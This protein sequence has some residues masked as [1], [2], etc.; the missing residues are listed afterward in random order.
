MGFVYPK[1]KFQS[2]PDLDDDI[3]DGGLSMVPPGR[4]LIMDVDDSN[5]GRILSS[6]VRCFCMCVNGVNN[7]ISI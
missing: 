3:V 1:I 2:Y 6:S 5:Y 4:S 7:E